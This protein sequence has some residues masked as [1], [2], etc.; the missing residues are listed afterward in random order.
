MVQDFDMDD[1][2]ICQAAT[3]SCPGGG[4]GT[5]MAYLFYDDIVPFI[6]PAPYQVLVDANAAICTVCDETGNSCIP[7]V[8]LNCAITGSD[9]TN[10]PDSVMDFSGNDVIVKG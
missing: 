4:V 3:T 2:I 6:G 5:R 9:L 1:K 8:T 10:M 7:L